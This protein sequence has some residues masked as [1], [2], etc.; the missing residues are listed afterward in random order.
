MDYQEN[1]LQTPD[2][3]FDWCLDDR[4]VKWQREQISIFGQQILVPREIA[5]FGKVGT[6]YRYSGIDHHGKNWPVR[7]HQLAQQINRQF[8][9]KTNFSLLNLYA[10]GD[11]YMGW[12]RDNEPSMHS[13][14]A[15][16]SLGETRRFRFR[17]TRRGI[18]QS[19]DL[20]HGSVLIF[21]GNRYHALPKSKKSLSPRINLT[22]RQLVTD[23]DSSAHCKPNADLVNE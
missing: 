22:F 8:D 5:W 10:S 15:S 12:H 17:D 18:S 9:L 16:V 11:D 20:V 7:I 6:N 3:L 13:L 19:I 1:F 21:D 23:S 14:I 4:N 2:A